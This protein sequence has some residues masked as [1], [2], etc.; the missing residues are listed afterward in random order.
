MREAAIL[1]L[2]P[3]NILSALCLSVE[4]D[5]G[6]VKGSLLISARLLD[7]LQRVHSFN[8]MSLV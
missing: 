1:F 5:D 7:E 2:S 8:Q 3:L 6:N 4:F